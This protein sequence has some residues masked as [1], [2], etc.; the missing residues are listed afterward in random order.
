MK[1]TCDK[2]EHWT[3]ESDRFDIEKDGG[4]YRG[5]CGC[6]KFSYE[7]PNTEDGLVYWDYDGESAGFQTGPKFGCV[8]FK[9]RN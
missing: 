1:K 8:H 3:L 5:G 4:D 2:C 7:G 9:K 6:E